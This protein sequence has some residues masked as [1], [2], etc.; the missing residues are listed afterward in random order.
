[1]IYMYVCETYKEKMLWYA[2]IKEVEIAVVSV[3]KLQNYYN[4]LRKLY[5]GM[6][7]RIFI[8]LRIYFLYLPVFTTT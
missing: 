7:Q 8:Y 2:D 1:M 6:C 3:V 4:D 5:K